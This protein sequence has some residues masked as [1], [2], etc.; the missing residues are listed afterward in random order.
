LFVL[1][2]VG[3]VEQVFVDGAG[4]FIVQFA[5]RGGNAMNFGF[6]QGTEHGEKR[7]KTVQC[8]NHRALSFAFSY[9]GVMDFGS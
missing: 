4:A 5:L 8:P 3:G 6:E 9:N 7:S 2:N 1:T